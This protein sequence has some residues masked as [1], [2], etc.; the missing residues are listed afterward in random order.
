MLLCVFWG[1]NLSFC[2]CV[3]LVVFSRLFVVVCVRFCGCCCFLCVV[4]W[5]LLFKKTCCVLRFLF[6][7]P[8]V[9]ACLRFCVC[10][11]CFGGCLFLKV[12]VS[13]FV[14]FVLFSR[15]LCLFV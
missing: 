14:L 11:C 2:A 9:C 5:W 8:R 3:A 7:I 1:G 4:F 12:V 15:F 13:M 10:C 6:C